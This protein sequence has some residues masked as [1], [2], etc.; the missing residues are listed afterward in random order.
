M[1]HFPSGVNDGWEPS[2]QLVSKIDARLGAVLDSVLHRVDATHHF[3]LDPLRYY[4]QYAGVITHG[5]KVV[6]INGINA[7]V[8]GWGRGSDADTI[9]W[10]KVPLASCDAGVGRFGVVY[11]VDSGEFGKLEFT[12]SYRGPV[13]Y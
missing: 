11:D 13:R 2:E 1:R 9:A 4:R 7:D 5:S 6:Y 12:D 10:R 3:G 8:L